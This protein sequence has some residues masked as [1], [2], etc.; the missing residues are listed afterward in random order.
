[1]KAG[2][3]HPADLSNAA[4]GHAAFR[5]SCQFPVKDWELSI[6]AS[7]SQWRNWRA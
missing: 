2:C 7:W 6:S 3:P 4:W 1:L 5:G